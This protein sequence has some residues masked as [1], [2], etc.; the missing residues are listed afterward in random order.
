M[1]GHPCQVGMGR[2][3]RPRVFVSESKVESMRASGASWRTIAKELGVGIGTVRRAA[4]SRAKNVCGAPFDSGP[5]V[6]HV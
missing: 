1:L 5:E 4:Q 3:G 6:L 2:A